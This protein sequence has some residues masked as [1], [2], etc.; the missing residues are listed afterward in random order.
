MWFCYVMLCYYAKGKKQE[1]NWF[2]TNMF[3]IIQKWKEDVSKVL[4][5]SEKVRLDHYIP[6]NV[7]V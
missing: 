7:Q 1:Y 4:V 6:G 2:G 3:K 5:V